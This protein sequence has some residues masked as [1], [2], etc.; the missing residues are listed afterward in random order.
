VSVGRPS[1]RAARPRLSAPGPFLSAAKRFEKAA[2]PSLTKADGFESVAT[3]LLKTASRFLSIPN[4]SAIFM[5]AVSSVA[6]ALRRVRRAP[7]RV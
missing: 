3:W 4:R 5:N 2:K 7:E 1:T 6:K